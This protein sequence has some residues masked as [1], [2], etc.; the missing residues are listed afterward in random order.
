MAVAIVQED[1]GTS[2]TSPQP[3]Y[4][5]T[6]AGDT[7]AG[8]QVFLCVIST[9]TVVTPSGFSLDRAQVNA[10]G[11]YIYRKASSAEAASWL[12]NP[13]GSNAA[14]WWVAEVS[15][16]ETSPLDQVISTGATSGNSSR[17]TGTTGT[18]VQANE[19]L[20][21]LAGLVAAADPANTVDSWTESFVQHANSVTT[22]TSGN[23]ISADIA[24]RTVSATATYETTGSWTASISHMLLATYKIEAVATPALVIPRQQLTTVRL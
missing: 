7:V 4:T 17:S 10:L 21:S 22:E 20:L 3:D 12:F 11:C 23:N 19:W 5:A 15:G 14:V 2:G 6:L 16:L 9:A 8:N 24:L 1:T 13:G 18:T